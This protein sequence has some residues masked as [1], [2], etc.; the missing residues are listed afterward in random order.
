MDSLNTLLVSGAPRPVITVQVECSIVE[1]GPSAQGTKEGLGLEL[2]K[3]CDLAS[4][5]VKTGCLKAVRPER[6]K[7][8]KKGLMENVLFSF[9]WLS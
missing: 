6:Q 2:G 3:G 5:D 7:E 4:Q 1:V 9:W 8:A